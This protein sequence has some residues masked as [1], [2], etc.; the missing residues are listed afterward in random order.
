M[1]HPRLLQV[2]QRYECRCGYCG[3]TETDAGGEL[4]VDHYRPGAAGGGDDEENLVYA[5]ARCNQYKGDFFP[6]SAQRAQ[7]KR[8]LHPLHDDV[9][10]HLREDSQTGLLEPLTQTG[11]FH[12]ALLQ[13]NRPA[14]V[15]HRLRRRSAQLFETKQCL[16]EMENAHLR[17]TIGA[18]QTYIRE[19]HRALGL[20]TDEETSSVD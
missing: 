12:I 3:V 14:L 9:G 7:G 11:R 13:L 8:V 20:P 16:L 2:R 4:T 5:C 10:V 1:P 17:E 19:L 6:D 15:L 18:Q